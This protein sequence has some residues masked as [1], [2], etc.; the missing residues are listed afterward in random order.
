MKDVKGLKLE[1]S[2]VIQTTTPQETIDKICKWI[3]EQKETFSS[4]GVA[5]F[6]PLCLDKSSGAY[7]SCT[8]TPKIAWQN[9]PVLKQILSG[10][11]DNKKTN[12]FR[13]VFDT[14]CNILAKF[15]LENGGHNIKD[16]IAYITVGTGVGVGF[17]IN[18]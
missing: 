1:R 8:T 4:L 5:A 7:G 12:D 2:S 13:V 15:E 14:D 10:I 16:N 11:N 9:F 17:V 3:N 6:G 18:G